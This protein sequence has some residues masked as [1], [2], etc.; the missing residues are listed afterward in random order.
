MLI[1][2]C[3]EFMKKTRQK[4]G[5]HGYGKNGNLRKSPEKKQNYVNKIR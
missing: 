5:K 3:E 2:H 1:T 4:M